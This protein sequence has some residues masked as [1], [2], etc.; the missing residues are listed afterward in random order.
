MNHIALFE[1]LDEDTRDILKNAHLDPKELVPEAKNKA[2]DGRS[3][4]EDLDSFLKQLGEGVYNELMD[5]Y[6][7]DFDIFGYRRKPF[8]EL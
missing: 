4:K 7:I 5:I 3:A 1:T 6:E 8:S 2:K